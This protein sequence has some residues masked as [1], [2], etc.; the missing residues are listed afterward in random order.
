MLLR[1]DFIL[2]YWIFTWYILYIIKIISYSP[3]LIIMLGIFE[4]LITLIIM[5]LYGSN[6][7]T[8]IY[9]IIINII[10]KVIPFYTIRNDKIKLRDIYS[11]IILILIYLLW[12]KI[13]GESVIK[14]YKKILDSL[15]HNKNDT[16]GIAILT[17]IEKYIIQ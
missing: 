8:I 6:C 13:N 5:I 11:T 16:I 1:V 9:F 10:I 4:N 7:K 17:K 3:K 12:V 14:Y 15:I 2:S